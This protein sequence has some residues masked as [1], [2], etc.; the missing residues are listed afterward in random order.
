MSLGYTNPSSGS[1]SVTSFRIEGD[2]EN[3]LTHVKPADGNYIDTYELRLIAGEGLLDNDT[4]TRF[5]VNE[6]FARH[7]G[8]QTPKTSSVK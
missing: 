2:D 3:Y 8:F 1:V 7:L 4:I 5:V 6:K